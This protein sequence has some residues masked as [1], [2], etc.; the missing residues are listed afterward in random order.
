[1]CEKGGSGGTSSEKVPRLLVHKSSTAHTW[2]VKSQSR[3]ASGKK[4][5]SSKTWKQLRVCNV[6][7]LSMQ[8]G[9]CEIDKTLAHKQQITLQ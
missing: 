7:A 8:K 2:G 5:V 6:S 4:S 3:E 1:M 9:W